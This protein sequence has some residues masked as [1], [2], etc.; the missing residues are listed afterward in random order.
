MTVAFVGFRGIGKILPRGFQHSGRLIEKDDGLQRAGREFQEIVLRGVFFRSPIGRQIPGF[1]CIH[2][3]GQFRERKDGCTND[4]RN[5]TLRA[6][7]KFADGLDSVAEKLDADRAWRF[8]RKKIHDAA[9]LRELAGHFH[10]F[11][12]RISDGA[13]VRDETVEADFVV[14]LE[15]AR[16]KFV[17]FS[18]T[19][20]PERGQDRRNQKRGLPRGEAI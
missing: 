2:G 6:R 10:H 1:G 18:G 20:T 16:K 12:A 14:G 8:R 15:R 3:N 9:A 19:I 4:R 17:A 7:V 13:E 5:R 11:R